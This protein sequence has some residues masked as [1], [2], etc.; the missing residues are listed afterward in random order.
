MT[1]VFFINLETEFNGNFYQ[2]IT[3]DHKTDSLHDFWENSVAQLGINE[4]YQS[5]KF[6]S[7]N[8]LYTI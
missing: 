1:Y 5:Y 2:I 6:K 3:M 8:F 4:K 7:I